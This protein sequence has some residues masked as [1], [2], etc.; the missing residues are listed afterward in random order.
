MKSDLDKLK[1]IVEAS[2]KLTSTLDLDEL[3]NVILDVALNELEAERG[4]VFLLDEE[5]GEIFSRI[6]RGNEIDE[7]RLPVGDGI[8]GKVAESGETIII[9]DAYSDPRF[10]PEVDRKS[11]FRTRSVLCLPLAKDKQI[12]GVIQLLNKKEDYFTQDDADYLSAL[13]SHMVIAIENARFHLERLEQERT[14]KELELAAKIQQRLLPQSTP[15]I[16]GLQIKTLYTPCHSVGGDLYDFL[17][18]PYGRLGI[19]LTDVA[20]KGIPAALITSA[21]HAYMHALVE[22][23]NEPAEFCTRLN[24]LL[25]DSIPAASYATFSFAEYDPERSLLRY[26]NC[27]HN[28]SLFIRGGEP[29]LLEATGT[30]LGMFPSMKFKQKE[31]E[32]KNGDILL[33]YTDG[34]SEASRGDS[35]DWE[36][37]GVDRL[38]ELCSESSCDPEKLIE[39]IHRIVS[40]F[41]SFEPLDDDLTILAFQFGEHTGED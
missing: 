32:C 39:K 14:R 30:V 3:L 9:K 25:F 15:A 11:G 41:T 2:K 26:C 10:N 1:A 18:L 40:E 4:T 27:G 31:L 8:S 17:E 21:L 35:N 34:L 13:A 24:N 19:V 16:S 38:I 33:L 12:L 22:T 6:L 29:D 5:A 7:I 20:G 28:P 23:Y 37:F 36:E